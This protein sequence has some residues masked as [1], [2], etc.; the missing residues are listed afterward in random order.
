MGFGKRLSLRP[1]NTSFY[2]GIHCALTFIRMFWGES[3]SHA[4][5]NCDCTFKGLKR[6]PKPPASVSLTT[7]RL[8]AQKCLWY[9]KVYRKI[10]TTKAVEY[11]VKKY[12]SHCKVHIQYERVWTFLLLPIFVFAIDLVNGTR[13]FNVYRGHKQAKGCR[14]GWNSQFCT[15]ESAKL[16]LLR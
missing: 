2:L 5:K 14:I 6:A 3:N 16:V 12:R 7:I 11:A 15:F 8:R 13:P 10:M 1:A 9:M 4:R